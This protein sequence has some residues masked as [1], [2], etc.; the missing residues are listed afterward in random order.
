MISPYTCPTCSKEMIAK[1]S[2]GKLIGYACSDIQC[3][4]ASIGVL[5]VEAYLT[6]KKTRHAQQ[7]VY[8]TK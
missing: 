7:L 1:H 4:T 3:G 5:A 6:A 8:S 2:R